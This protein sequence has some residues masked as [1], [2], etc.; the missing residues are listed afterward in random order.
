MFS[1]PDPNDWFKNEYVTQIISI[2][3]IPRPFDTTIGK[4]V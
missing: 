3:V 1:T 4:E 2:R